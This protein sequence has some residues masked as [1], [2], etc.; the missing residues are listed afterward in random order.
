MGRKH[1]HHHGAEAK[2]SGHHRKHAPSNNSAAANYIQAVVRAYVLRKSQHRDLLRARLE[3]YAK[4]TPATFFRA[5]CKFAQQTTTARALRGAR[6]LL[7]SAPRD[8]AA[9]ASRRRQ[10]RRRARAQCAASLFRHHGVCASAARAR[11]PPPRPGAAT[12]A[13]ARAQVAS[14]G[15][16]ARPAT[17][18]AAAPARAPGD[19]RSL[20]RGAPRVVERGSARRERAPSDRRPPER[21]GSARPPSGALRALADLRVAPRHAAR[22]LALFEDGAPTR[23]AVLDALSELGAFSEYRVAGPRAGQ[24]RRQRAPRAS[25]PG[26][27]A[28]GR[29]PRRARAAAA[30]AAAAARDAAAPRGAARRDD[31]AGDAGRASPAPGVGVAAEYWGGLEG[32]RELKWLF[33]S[34]VAQT[35]EHM[36]LSQVCSHASFVGELLSNDGIRELLVRYDDVLATAFA[37]FSGGKARLGF[38]EFLHMLSVLGLH[39]KIPNDAKKRRG[40]REAATVAVAGSDLGRTTAPGRRR[41]RAAPGG[42]G[43]RR[44]RLGRAGLAA[45]GLESVRKALHDQLYVVFRIYCALGTVAQQSAKKL[46]LETFFLFVNDI[47]L[48]AALGYRDFAATGAGVARADV[49]AAW[50][51]S[52]REKAAAPVAASTA[53]P[54]GVAATELARVGRGTLGVADLH[55]L[56]ADAAGDEPPETVRTDTESDDGAASDREASRSSSSDDDGAGDAA[57]PARARPSGPARRAAAANAPAAAPATRSS[58]TRTRRTRSSS[59]RRG[60][61]MAPRPSSAPRASGKFARRRPGGRRVANRAP[62]ARREP[63][64]RPTAGRA[65]AGAARG[66]SADPQARSSPAARAD[67]AQR[68]CRAEAA[69]R[70]RRRR[71]GRA[72]R[73][74]GRAGARRR[75]RPPAAPRGRGEARPGDDQGR[76]RVIQ[77]RFNVSVPF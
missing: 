49:S 31:A 10:R 56:V 17:A 4:W 73:R 50:S 32:G 1:H 60:P 19:P 35:A 11:R 74:R 61:E 77:R 16:G 58:P 54:D 47:S 39:P 70:R 25:G 15:R 14:T 28:S 64:T 7:R 65:A 36:H 76:K 33:W 30:A 46:C 42:G 18:S 27:G 48:Y 3:A 75:A 23:R 45:R 38:R 67:A 66:R 29:A 72:G 59:S 57:R 40:G 43:R 71:R 13:P 22:C 5:Y 63:P 44:R 51:R 2:P 69:A 9:S 62:S 37:H 6:Y 26:G 41:Q 12:A 34:R 52:A 20:R 68:R 21:R 53:G 55:D 8:R 24:G